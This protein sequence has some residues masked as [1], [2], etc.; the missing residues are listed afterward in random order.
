MSRYAITTSNTLR[1][2]RLSLVYPQLLPCRASVHGFYVNCEACCS[3]ALCSSSHHRS[4]YSSGC[5]RIFH[6]YQKH[7]RR[8]LLV[9]F[10]RVTIVVLNI[11]SPQYRCRVIIINTNYNCFGL[12]RFYFYT[13]SGMKSISR[14]LGPSPTIYYDNNRVYGPNCLFVST[15]VFP[16][17]RTAYTA[18]ATSTAIISLLHS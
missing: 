8:T 3:T 18:I 6:P 12:I 17:R 13:I 1:Y 14:L 5:T 7:T 2:F 15:Y 11:F 16:F 4:S 9:A 10:L